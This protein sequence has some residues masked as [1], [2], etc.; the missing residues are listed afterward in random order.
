ML[1][2][3]DSNTAACDL[4]TLRTQLAVF[5]AVS[6]V[7]GAVRRWGHIDRTG[8]G[9]KGTQ[10]RMQTISKDQRMPQT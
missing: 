8:E 2:Q 6:F 5:L 10:K 4:D 1:I 7:S 3:F 9:E